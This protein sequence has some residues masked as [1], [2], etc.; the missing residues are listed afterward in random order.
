MVVGILTEKPS[1][2]RHLAAALGGTRGHFNGEEFVIAHARGHLYEFVDPHRMVRDPAL[3]AQYKAWDLAHLPWA[4]DDFTWQLEADADAEPVAREVKRTLAECDE[5]VIATDV[6]PSGEGGMIAVNA[7]R[8]LDLRPTSWS[9]MYFTDEAAPSLQRAFTE[10]RPILSLEDFD[11]YK[12]AVY[13]SKFDF[14]SMQWTR[15]ATV[16]ARGTGRDVVLRQGRLKSAMVT[17][18]GDQLKAH[19]EYVKRPYFQSR[20]RDEN[21]VTYTNQKEPRFEDRALVPQQYAAAPVVID[22]TTVKY[23]A[24]PKL[25]DLAALSAMLVGNGTTAKQVLEIYQRMYEAQVVSYPRTEDKTITPEQFAELA[26]LINKIAAVVDVD[27]GI[28]T[29]RV[30]RATHVKAQGAHGANRP[31]P[32]VPASLDD[33]AGQ[34]GQTGRKIYEVL[35]RNYLAMLADD[36]AYEQQKGHLQT[37]PEFVGIANVPQTSGWKVVFDPDA[38]K[39]TKDD[40]ASDDGGITDSTAGL[41]TS[42]APFVFEGANKR[43]EHPSMS[44]LMK[45][46]DK[47][48]V[49]TGA[50]RTSTYSDVTNTA[51]AHPLLEAQGRKVTLA[52]A[53]AISWRLLHGT[54]IG[55][56]TLTEKVYAD[57]REIAAGTATAEERLT[58]V[59][60]WVR[61]DIATMTANA[62][63]LGRKKGVAPEREKTAGTWQGCEVSFAREW[64]GHRFTDDEVARLLAGETI[65]FNAR[66][67][68][69]TTYDVFGALAEQQHK[70]R[71]F[72]GFAK[73]GFGRRDATGA[74]LPPRQWCSHTFTAAELKQ[75]MTGEAVEATDFVSKKGKRFR[76]V[77]TFEEEKKGEGKKI[78]ARFP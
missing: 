25:L 8:E 18:V 57:M 50:T 52:A 20:F 11:E 46:L 72:V 67:A 65:E 61:E 75:L 16:L 19:L 10:R 76:C 30:P 17:L 29:R 31:G 44:W 3:Q 55:D 66:S 21:G 27:P 14:L 51:T 62:A 36:Y 23:T 56:L 24:P 4:P 71:T 54:R 59:A 33:V 78:I 9:R 15:C 35:A 45:Q 12:K 32:N 37:Y 40:S 28:L 70:G 1:A 7:F 73:Q 26:P 42:A 22:D 64:G 49:G 68:Q 38:G 74:A 43:P 2:A 34:F 39:E 53:G 47:R 5:L 13:R 60:E 48:D 41:G 77:V 63:A 69:G 58:V 6:D